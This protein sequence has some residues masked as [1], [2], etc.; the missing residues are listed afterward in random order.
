MASLFSGGC[1]LRDRDHSSLSFMFNL[2]EIQDHSGFPL[3]TLVPPTLKIH[4]GVCWDQN[5][6]ITMLCGQMPHLTLLSNNTS[7]AS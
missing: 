1:V 2:S 4:T 5:I 7:E 6:I 3:S